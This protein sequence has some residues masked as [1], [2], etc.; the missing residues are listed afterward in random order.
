MPDV[1][2]N[3]KLKRLTFLKL[4][5]VNIIDTYLNNNYF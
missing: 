1:I 2:R 5:S 4:A 3:V